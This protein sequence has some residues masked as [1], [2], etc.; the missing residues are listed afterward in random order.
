[1]KTGEVVEALKAAQSGTAPGEDAI[2]VEMLKHSGDTGAEVLTRMFNLALGWEVVPTQWKTGIIIPLFKGG[3]ESDPKDYRGITLLSSVG[4]VL[5]GVIMG[6]LS[7]LIDPL[8]A[9]EQHGFRHGRGCPDA[10]YILETM[11]SNAAPI[12]MR[13]SSILPRHMTLFGRTGFGG[14]CT[15]RELRG[16]SGDFS[17]A[18][19]AVSVVAWQWRVLSQGI[20]RSAKGSVRVVF[21]LR[22]S[23][24]FSSTTLY[25]R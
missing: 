22:C 10:A 3:D 2:F 20:S 6:R 5:E 1:V 4:K 15:K 24:S 7:P 14:D 21:S 9:E 17:A 13:A 16:R 8:L 18:G 25:E 23:I 12:S 19:V 11:P